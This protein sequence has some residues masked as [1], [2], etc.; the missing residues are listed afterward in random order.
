MSNENKDI[1]EIKEELTKYAD[2]DSV[3]SFEEVLKECNAIATRTIL[4]AFGLSAFSDKVGG[5]VTTIH[6]FTQGITA[7]DRDYQK[8]IQYNTPYS[9]ER[10]RR[11][12]DKVQVPERRKRIISDE[13]LV[14]GY[15]GKRLP[16][17]GRTQL[18]HIVAVKEIESMPEN[19]LFMDK[20]ERVKLAYLEENLTMIESSANQSKGDIPL[21]EWLTTVNRGQTQTNAQRFDIDIDMAIVADEK[22]RKVIKKAQNRAAVSKQ[23]KELLSTGLKSGALLGVREVIA[24]ILIEFNDEAIICVKNIMLKRKVE[25][26]SF[27]N[28]L[29]EIKA[30]LINVKD[31]VLNKYKNYAEMFCTGFGSGFCSNLLTFLI[32]NFM[33][34]GKNAVKII[35]ES[36]YAFV[37]AGKI[38]CDK[39]YVDND[40]R[41]KDATD[42]IVSSVGIC[43][44]VLLGEAIHQYIKGIPYS[45]EIAQSASGIII[46]VGSVLIVYYFEAMQ[47]EALAAIAA[48]AR[49]EL[50]LMETS[51]KVVT[52]QKK[53]I[54]RRNDLKSGSDK[55]EN[56]KF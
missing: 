12:Y 10:D 33:T 24:A 3:T 45:D 50:T 28:A 37:R 26:I 41:I 14:S 30:G 51:E 29:Y 20:A 19:F 49:A 7:T 47:A 22:A 46:G 15:T 8:F 18:E 35:R 1:D 40:D 38:M 56:L 36:F 6:N 53:S 32:N 31:R 9:E 52:L 5:T 43:L 13:T 16:R 27:D 17:D 11:D 25:K 55:L 23:G 34:T 48:T 39:S 44:T 2:D 4:A 21:K 54:K 42:V